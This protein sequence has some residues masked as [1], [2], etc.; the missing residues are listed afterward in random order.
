MGKVK[1]KKKSTFIDMTAMSDVTV[2]L[3]TFFMLTS[4]FLQKEPTIVYTPSSV[5]EEKVPVSNLVTILISSADKG[6]VPEGK[7]ATEAEG[8]IFISF[9]GGMD[10][11][12]V[13]PV[14]RGKMLDEALKVYNAQAK[15][16]KKIALTDAQKKVFQETNMLGTSFEYLPELL[17]KSL[18][19]I[20]KEQGDMYNPNTGIPIDGNKDKNGH[21]NDFQIWCRAI[22][23]VSKELHDNMAT[24][25]G[26]TVDEAKTLGDLYNAITKDGTGI[27]IKADKD[28]P[29]T[30]V[31]T[32]FDNLQTMSL[33]KFSL[34]TA[35]TSEEEAAPAK[36]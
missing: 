7:D 10:S 4:T 9:S 24:D 26:L 35:L 14:I 16:S 27:A 34:M 22:Y 15:D 36:H 8:K 17:S 20:D 21:L 12:Q 11:T 23:T 6:K 29:F 25:M 31:E 2:L 19:E 30:T 32:V 13:A 18:T 3:L 1:I 28:T 5:S 33:N